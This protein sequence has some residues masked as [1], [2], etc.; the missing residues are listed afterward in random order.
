MAGRPGP[1]EPGAPK[2]TVLDPIAPQPAAPQPA[3]PQPAAPRPAPPKLAAPDLRWRPHYLLLAPHRLAFFLAL[4]LLAGSA[5]WWA[6]VQLGMTRS[7]RTSDAVPAPV[8]HAALMACGFFPLFFSGFLFT[9]GPKW[10]QVA[11]WPMNVLRAPLLLLAAGW[12][13][14][15]LAAPHS[16]VAA[17]AGATGA[18]AGMAWVTM[19]FGRLLVQSRA[20]DQLHARI[21]GFAFVV[22]SCCVAGLAACTWL[23]EWE[24]ARRWVLTALWGFAVLIFVTVAHRML[25]FFSPPGPNGDHPWGGLGLL[26]GA[27]GFEVL[28]VW[29]D[30]LHAGRAPWHG[31]WYGLRAVLELACAGLLLW[32]AWGWAQRQSLRNRLLRMFYLG[33]LWLGLALLLR[34]LA[35]VAALA[36]VLPG[37]ELAALHALGMGCLGTLMLAMVTRVSCGHSGRAQVADAL[38]WG[39]FLLWQFATVLRLGAALGGAAAPVLLAIAALLW[40]TGATVWA[41]RLGSWY[42]RRRADGRAG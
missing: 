22:G 4:L 11:P 15:L 32:R 33:F 41:L 19:L 16:R 29:I 37:A 39:L 36:G 21:V 7:A 38:L 18:C 1:G 31:A 12:L 42:G 40:T 27:V 30:A 6:S 17:A 3:A 14:W 26:A 35:S 5:W 25:P 28:A 9:A 24:W 20:P 10:L 2:S 8:V 34:G 23:G 13:A